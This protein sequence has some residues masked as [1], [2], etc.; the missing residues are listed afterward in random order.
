M[1]V[2]Q[3]NCVYNKGSTG[4]I[5][6]DI[7]NSLLENQIDSVICYG[8]GEKT[9][10]KGVYK[11]CGEL[12]SKINNLLS[13]I[14]GL[15]YGGC[16]F[17]T[18]KLISII[19]R[20]KP[21]VVHL[22]CINGYFVNIYRLVK[23]LNKSKIKTVLTLHA[24]F[25]HTA[26]CGHALDCDKWKSGC[27]NCPR[28][29]KE[30]KSWLID[31]THRSFVKM[32]KAFD[33][34][35]NL[36]VTSVSPWL[37]ERA[38][39][40]PILADK[41]HT[42]VLNGLDTNIFKIYDTSDLREK[43][44]IAENEKVVFHATPFF[45]D[46]K[47]SFKGGYYILELARSLPDVKFIVAGSVKEGISVPNNLILLGNVSNQI[48]LAKYYSL[49][50]LTVIA[51]KK[52]T[53]SM[54]LAEGMA[55]GTPVVGFYAG[56]PETITIEEYSSFVKYGDFEALKNST[57]ELLNKSLDKQ[58]ISSKAREK[59]DKRKMTNGYI[60]AYLSLNKGGYYGK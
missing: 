49:A 29:K 21:D 11:T 15:M 34:F 39:Q 33:G 48:D 5:M 51:S 17:S 8:R 13:R 58:E 32:K 3:I 50:D 44:Q 56:G 20:E 40:S 47:D 24:E 31:G 10:D 42:V 30:T 59:Y 19:K 7:H 1:K 57:I 22:H 16:F 2:M 9:T 60:S 46:D 23:W 25:M 54:I 14:S 28:L 41:K 4:K 55:C 6:C 35:E 27:G 52:E 26:N 38:K 53:F 36:I 12:Y 45:S 43:H 37:M 18:N